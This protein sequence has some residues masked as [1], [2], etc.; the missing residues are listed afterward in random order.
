MGLKPSKH[1]AVLLQEQIRIKL[2]GP[3]SEAERVELEELDANIDA[4]LRNS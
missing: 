1:G 3:V 2:S 4:Y